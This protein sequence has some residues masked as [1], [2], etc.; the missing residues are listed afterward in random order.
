MVAHRVHRKAER[1]GDLRI[2]VSERDMFDDFA[3]PRCEALIDAHEPSWR[4]GQGHAVE[5]L[6]ECIARGQGGREHLHA[7]ENA[8]GEGVLT[9][10]EQGDRGDEA[11]ANGEMHHTEGALADRLRDALSEG[12]ARFPRKHLVGDHWLPMGAIP[13]GTEEA[14]ELV[15]VSHARGDLAGIQP[16]DDTRFD[17]NTG[18]ERVKQGR[19]EAHDAS[20]D[21]QSPGP[22]GAEVGGTDCK[23]AERFERCR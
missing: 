13:Q 22:V 11:L 16:H 19:V 3:L 18:G 23:L 2:R 5:P 15:P 12:G 4:H 9:P 17:R 21:V 14:R 1:L 6:M 7:R 20:D 8:A 10:R